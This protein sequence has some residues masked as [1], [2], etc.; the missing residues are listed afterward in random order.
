MAQ[1][2]RRVDV[3]DK[4]L[5]S[6]SLRFIELTLIFISTTATTANARHARIMPTAIFLSDLQRRGRENYSSALNFKG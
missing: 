6:G 1:A 4:V 5:H 2:I 3:I